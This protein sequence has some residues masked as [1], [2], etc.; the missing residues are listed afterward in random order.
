MVLL[1][2][3]TWN[4]NSR[5]RNQTGTAQLSISFITAAPKLS[6]VQLNALN[7]MTDYDYD[8]EINNCTYS[9]CFWIGYEI[10]FFEQ[11]F[12]F[13]SLHKQEKHTK[14]NIVIFFPIEVILAKRLTVNVKLFSKSI[15]L[16]CHDSTDNYSWVCCGCNTK[17]TTER[18]PFFPCKY[19]LL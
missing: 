11:N 12:Y 5:F 13:D 17:L 10:T 2:K 16:H 19:A 1:S 6:N 15:W 7:S 9:R 18:F 14:Y 4:Y 3:V 8:R